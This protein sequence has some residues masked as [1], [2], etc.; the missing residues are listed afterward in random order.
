MEKADDPQFAGLLHSFTVIHSF[1][2]FAGSAGQAYL[3]VRA[4]K[5]SYIP[6]VA[7]LLAALLFWWPGLHANQRPMVGSSGGV[8]RED[9]G[10]VQGGGCFLSPLWHYLAAVPH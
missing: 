6:A 2:T 10:G 1:I 7:L 4:N 5:Y 9:V 8:R 3:A